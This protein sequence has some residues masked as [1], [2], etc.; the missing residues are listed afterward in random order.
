[1]TAGK[2][3]AELVVLD[4]LFKG[5]RFGGLILPEPQKVNEIWREVAKLIVPPKEINGPVAGHAHEPGLGILGKAVNRPH[6]QSPAKSV[7]DY[8]LCQVEAA[9]S[10]NLG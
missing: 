7:L 6:F 4:F 3:H 8:V 9:Q 10:E 5:R 2:H 1:M